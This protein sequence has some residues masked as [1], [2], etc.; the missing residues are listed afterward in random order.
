MK[1]TLEIVQTTT[2]AVAQDRQFKNCNHFSELS[3]SQIE[4]V[5]KH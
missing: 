1:S 3:T 4:N 2:N 5:T